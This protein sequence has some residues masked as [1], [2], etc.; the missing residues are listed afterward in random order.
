MRTG[1]AASTGFRDRL[2]AFL[3]GGC[4]R[5]LNRALSCLDTRGALST[6]KAIPYQL[7][8][9]VSA[10][11]EIFAVT[12]VGVFLEAGFEIGVVLPFAAAPRLGRRF[13]LLTVEQR[14]GCF[15]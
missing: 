4:R 13:Y 10:R 6:Q 2:S 15:K 14:G 9:A 5:H 7:L 12:G 11:G 8:C 1:S 3:G